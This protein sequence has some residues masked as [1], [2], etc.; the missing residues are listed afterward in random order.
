[1]T[2][3]D[4]SQFGFHY[5]REDGKKVFDCPLVQLPELNKEQIVILDFEESVHTRYGERTLVKF[6]HP[7]KGEGKFITASDEMLSALKFVREQ[8]GF[9][10]RTTIT[11]QELG[12]GKVKYMFN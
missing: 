11:R 4:F 9:P 10:F 12:R 3:K 8:E 1:M 2:I 5:E 7:D 6:Q